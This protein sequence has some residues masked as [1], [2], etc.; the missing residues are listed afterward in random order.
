MDIHGEGTRSDK[1]KQL[2][3][4]NININYI[5]TLYDGDERAAG[6]TLL[7]RGYMDRHLMEITEHRHGMPY[8]YERW[9]FTAGLLLLLFSLVS[10]LACR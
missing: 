4:I 5:H 1:L 8:G 9:S 3:S 2:Q 10:A 7:W 6:Y